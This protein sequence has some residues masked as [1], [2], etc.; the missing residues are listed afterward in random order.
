MNQRVAALMVVVG[1]TSAVAL[2]QTPDA[3]SLVKA[4]LPAETWTGAAPAQLPATLQDHVKALKEDPLHG[5]AFKVVETHGP[6]LARAVVVVVPQFHR[7]PLLPLLWNSIGEAIAG[8]QE[9]V[10]IVTTRLVVAHGLRCVGT[11]GSW[12]EVIVRSEEQ[13]QLA[14]AV[15]ELQRSAAAIRTLDATLGTR[16]SGV[17]DVMLPYLRRQALTLDGVGSALWRLGRPD[18]KRFGLEEQALNTRALDLLARMRALEEQLARLEPEGQADVEDAMAQTWRDEYPAFDRD[19][20]TPLLEGLAA[21]DT[22]RL[23]AVRDGVEADAAVL[24]R[25]VKLART[26]RDEVLRVED[27]TAYDAYYR[28]VG[29]AVTPEKPRKPPTRAQRAQAQ[30]LKKRLVPLQATYERVAGPDREAA[31]VRR[32]L[33]HLG[34]G[35]GLCLLV[36]GAN[37]QQGVVDQLRKPANS[38]V[39]VVVVEPYAVEEAPPP[40]AGAP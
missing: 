35:S 16:A 5:Q 2:G 27:V 37:H 18:V 12:A 21:L 6:L 20:V 39:G 14:S 38:H 29:R 4:L 26:L 24:G 1:V 13:L 7:S 8:V 22:A 34:T 31:A 23:A 17:V 30:K 36:M 25:F 40:D 19:V 11:E 3:A 9:N 10:D 32:V 15:A 28:D 33:Q